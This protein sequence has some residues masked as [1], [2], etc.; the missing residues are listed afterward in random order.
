ML[1][2]L[3]EPR[4]FVRISE[5]PAHSM[6]ARTAP[7][8]MTPAPGAAGFIQTRPAPCL[9]TTSCGIV[10][11]V[12]GIRRHATTCRVDG[13]A[14]RLRHFIRLARRE[15]DFA[16]TV[17]NG[18]ERVEREPPATLHDLGD[19]IDR[20]HVLEQLAAV[21]TAIAAPTSPPRGRRSPPSRP[22]PPPD[23]RR[24]PPG[25][26]P[27][28]P[29][30]PGP[31]AHHRGDSRRRVHHRRG[32]RAPTAPPRLA[33]TRRALGRS[34][35]F[36]RS[37]SLPYDSSLPRAPLSYVKKFVRGDRLRSRARPRAPRRPRPSRGRGTCTPRDRRRPA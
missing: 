37:N 30:P 23:R 24:A 9:P 3:V 26:P 8:A 6:I 19:A 28:P 1:C 7:P 32:R 12:S 34:S 13:L 17:A 31:P 33:W 11:P 29:G 21:A 35:G 5:I 20:D 10:L 25:P 18:D 14:H 2:G 16:L 36:G 15:S 22:P 27:R 4:L